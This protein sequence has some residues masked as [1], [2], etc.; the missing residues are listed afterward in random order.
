MNNWGF[1]RSCLKKLAALLVSFDKV[2]ADSDMR[3]VL[4]SNQMK[5][6][7]ILTFCV[8]FV[9]GLV[10]NANAQVQAGSPEDKAFQ[11][12]DAESNTDA[13]VT[14]LLDFEKQFPQSR[15]LREAYLQLLQI[16]Q[17]K[18]DSA[19]VIEYSEKTIKVD[20]SNLTALLTVT[21]AYSLD[22]KSASLDRAIQYGQKAVDE[23]AKLK[24]SPPQQGYTDVDWKK[25]IDSNDQ[26]AKSYLSYAKS[27][28]R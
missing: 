9:W 15:A 20:P 8:V 14:M 7:V 4:R 23:I 27:L 22:G 19:K 26:L 16:Y 25:Y 17:E 6:K 28:K 21:R 1:S 12:I 24:G 5:T 10:S 11:K 3:S 13:K 18:N 2:A